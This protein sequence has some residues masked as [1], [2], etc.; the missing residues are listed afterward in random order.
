LSE[1]ALNR[2]VDS[3]EAT[4]DSSVF[5]HL[6]PAYNNDLSFEELFNSDL[7]FCGKKTDKKRIGGAGY[8]DL[9]RL[10]YD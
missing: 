4:L 5:F 3:C 1:N 10:F 2:F 6:F 9:K 8:T 7:I